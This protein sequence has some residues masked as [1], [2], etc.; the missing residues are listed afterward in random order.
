MVRRTDKA[1]T[2][3]PRGTFGC[4]FFSRTSAGGPVATA[5]GSCRARRK[6]FS[7][8][9]I[10]ARPTTVARS[11]LWCSM[12]V[13]L[14][15]CGTAEPVEMA[16]EPINVVDQQRRS[17]LRQGLDFLHRLDEFNAAQAQDKIRYHLQQWMK[18]QRPHSEW[19]ADPLARRLPQRFQPLVSEERLSRLELES[20]DVQMLQE[21]VWLRD[22]AQSVV[23][24]QTVSPDVRQ[25]IEATA[26]TIDPGRRSDLVHALLLFD[27]VVRNLQLDEI[28]QDGRQRF[29]SDV[30]LQAWE[31]LLM[32]RGT[33]E[34]TSRVFL[35]LA[36]Q[37]GLTVTMLGIDTADA[38][39]AP[40]PWL[41]AVLLGDQLLLLEMRLGLPIEGPDEW[42]VATL[43]QVLEQPGLLSRMSVD[44]TY[45]VGSDDLRSLVAMLDATPG[46]L[47]QRMRILETALLG[48]QKMVLTTAPSSIS[49]T[50]RRCRGIS[51]V[52]IWPM[53]YE[54][55]EQRSTLTP[56]SP[57]IQGLAREHTLFDRRTPLVRARQMHFRGQFEPQE[58]GPGARALYLE[59]R[60]PEAQIQQVVRA[61]R[62]HA[63]DV[64]GTEEDAKDQAEAV[65]FLMTRTKQN[66]SYWLGLLAFEEGQYRVA[67]DYFEKRLLGPDAAGI[68]TAGARY[69]LG[70]A[71]EALGRQDDDRERL[72]Q[73]QQSYRMVDDSPLRDGCQLRARRLDEDLDPTD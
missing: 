31:S 38:A 26:A 33:L 73:A 37:L 1:E 36:R 51:R 53:P 29:A 47:S 57:Q 44:G 54:A 4:Q 55:F 46:Y 7:C 22:I 43:D 9:V 39:E 42:S 16:A 70:R 60:T 25:W 12:L 27:W 14:S 67:I 20:Y 2:F 11:A 58:E 30:T 18:K 24:R 23:R 5:G 50:L 61:L 66:A 71:Q 32:G 68:W 8:P 72:Q 15:G 63:T 52:Q 49:T 17:D 3:V 35:L 69:N 59:C 45:P 40:R 6:S 41:P 65:E 28:Q 10:R 34:E 19:I 48:E 62:E 13:L 21:A 64:A 56:Q